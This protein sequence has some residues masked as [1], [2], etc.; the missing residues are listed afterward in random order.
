[1]KK[2][3]INPNNGDDECFK[4]VVIA[5][6]HHEEIGKDPQR[7]NK[8]KPFAERYKW[9]G[10]DWRTFLWLSTR[11]VSLRREILGSW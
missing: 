10:L 6:L 5:A 8:L 3:V 9:G 7:V 4:Y 11:L 1:M 2:A